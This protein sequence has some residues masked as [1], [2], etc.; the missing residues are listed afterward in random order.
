MKKSYTFNYLKIYL[1]QGISI[2]TNLLSMVIVIPRLS[3]NPSIYG[4]YVVCISANIFLTY[5]DIGFASAAY[6]YAS[7]CYARKNIEEEIEVVGFLG[8]ILLIFVILFA[9]AVSAVAL[10]PSLLIKN[11]NNVTEL[12]I[13]T[14]LLFIL[15]L[16]SPFIIFQRIASLIYGIRLEQYVMQ[17][18]MSAA[19]VFK[20]LSVFYF[21]HNTRYDIIGYFLFCQVINILALIYCLVIAKCKYKYNYKAFLK[22]FRFSKRWFSKSKSLAFGSLFST[23]TWVLYYELDVFFIAKYLG[24]EKVAL[25]AVGF[26]MLSFFRTIMGFIFSP[27]DARFN[28]FIGLNDMD[29]LRTIYINTVIVTLPIVTFPIVSLVLLM[30]PFMHSWVGE[31]YATS[32]LIAQLLVLVFIY[33]FFGQPANILI[34]AKEKI[35]LLYITSSILPIIYWVGVASTISN[36]GLLS[37]GLFKFIAMSMN[38]IILFMVSIKIL[39]LTVSNFINKIFKPAVIPL[40]FLILSLSY[41]NQFMPIEKSTINVLIVVLTGGLASGV[42][43][44]FYYIS[45]AHFRR[46][47]Q[48][49]FRKCFA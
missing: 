37:F 7:E 6:K 18:I 35:R 3:G 39:D 17:R 46:Y 5:A 12:N 11:L 27:F 49:L 45:S 32:V 16:F 47:S 1:W 29:G 43:L 4:I 2:V 30:R 44:S 36:M 21:F 31:N 42:A 9:L 15:S 22:A 40:C 8:F 19:N 33:G 25:Y 23:I 26:I 41:I 13:A 34:I 38:C 48:G 28:H 10:N 24:A 14:K 20:I